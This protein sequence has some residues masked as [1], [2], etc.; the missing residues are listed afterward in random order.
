MYLFYHISKQLKSCKFVIYGQIIKWCRML[1]AAKSQKVFSIGSHQESIKS[2]SV[3]FS[4]YILWKIAD[5]DFVDIF[6]DGTKLKI[7]PE[8]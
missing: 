3:N 8:I 5:K 1:K 6:E 2:M 4:Y 7:S